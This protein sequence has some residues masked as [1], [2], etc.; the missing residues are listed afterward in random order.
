MHVTKISIDRAALACFLIRLMTALIPVKRVRVRVRRRLLDRARDARTARLVPIVRARYAVHEQTC[1]DKL[2]RGERLRVAFLVCDASMFSAEPVFQAMVDDVRFDPFI[3][4]VPRVTRGE[5]FLRETLAKTLETLAPRYTGK[6][7]ALYDPESKVRRSLAGR[8]DIVFTSIV[9]SDQT[10][11]DYTSESLSEQALT[12]YIPYGYSGPLAADLRRLVFLPELA[13]FWQG[14]VPVE[15]TRA[16]WVKANPLLAGVLMVGGY[17]KMD[18]LS[19]V[20]RVG[21]RAKTVLICPHHSLGRG[22]MKGVALSNFLRFSNFFLRLPTLFPDVHF[23][24]RPHPLL[25]PRLATREW[26]GERRVAEYRAAL[27]RLRNVTL[28]EGGDYFETFV[29]SDALVHDC[30]SFFAEYFYTGHPQCYI[31]EDNTVLTREFTE[32]GKRLH[33][34]VAHA[35]TEEDIIEFIR[36]TVV[37]GKDLMS[38][39]RQAFAANEVCLYHPHSVDWVVRKVIERIE[40]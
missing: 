36:T 6:V 18:R 2:A 17:P 9:Y 8:A 27:G 10:F 1:R 33:R 19:R 39:K 25:F 22:D 30:G 12:V 23:V 35:Q 14:V 24:F 20:G 40:R 26:W 7:E 11:P 32:F 4:I 38:E 16:A 13:L 28:Q 31:V 34:Y 5:A 37:N 3:A 15:S 21:N 29:N